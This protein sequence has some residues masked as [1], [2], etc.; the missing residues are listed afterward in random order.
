M[1]GQVI[2]VTS[3]LEILQRGAKARCAKQH[4]CGVCGWVGGWGG[5][6]GACVCVVGR[7][8]AMTWLTL[9]HAEKLLLSQPMPC[10]LPPLLHSHSHAVRCLTGYSVHVGHRPSLVSVV[11]GK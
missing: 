2:D 9:R 8:A 6:G 11:L 10:P 4:A 5:W 3:A 7:S 1:Y